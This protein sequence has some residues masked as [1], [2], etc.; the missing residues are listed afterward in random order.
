MDIKQIQQRKFEFDTFS[1]NVWFEISISYY[2]IY[3]TMV[4][5]KERRDQMMIGGFKAICLDF[6]NYIFTVDLVVR[7]V[8]NELHSFVKYV[9]LI[10]FLIIEN[11]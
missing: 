2:L 6:T 9:K 5:W 1:A 8:L 11:C 4:N 3:K 7:F 10:F